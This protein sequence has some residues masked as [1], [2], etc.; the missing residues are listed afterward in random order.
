LRVHQVRVEPGEVTTP[1]TRE[2]QEEVFAAMTDGEMA[3]DGEVHDVPA[4]VVV[5]IHPD[6]VWDLCNQTDDRHV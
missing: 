2:G 1:H 4:D 3:I 6:T 5:R